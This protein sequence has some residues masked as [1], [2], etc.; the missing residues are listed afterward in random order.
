IM[1]TRGSETNFFNLSVIE[2]ASCIGVR[3]A[4]W[5]SFNRGSEI[6]PSARTG[7]VAVKSGSFHTDTDNVS[8][9]PMMYE[10]LTWGSACLDSEGLE[11]AFCAHVGK[12]PSMS[13][14]ATAIS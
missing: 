8:S 1:V 10:G 5:T 6:I 9:G 11:G 2:A 3:P 4:A 14:V 13:A 7:K 12:P